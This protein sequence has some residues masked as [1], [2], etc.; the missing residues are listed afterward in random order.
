[1]AQNGGIIGPVKCVSTPQTKINTFIESST[2][3]K[4]NC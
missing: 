2:F 1:M 3:K 4:T